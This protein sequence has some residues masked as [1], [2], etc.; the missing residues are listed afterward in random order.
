[1]ITPLCLVFG[2][3]KLGREGCALLHDT[4]TTFLVV[5]YFCRWLGVTKSICSRAGGGD[6]VAEFE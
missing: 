2:L 5:I 4:I 6:Q 3:G 1:M